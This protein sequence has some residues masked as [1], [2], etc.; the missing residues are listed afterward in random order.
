MTTI[1]QKLLKRFFFEGSEAGGKA[2]GAGASTLAKLL[3]AS[4]KKLYL[5]YLI[6]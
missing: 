5:Q 6:I 1:F 2:G 3:C 4:K